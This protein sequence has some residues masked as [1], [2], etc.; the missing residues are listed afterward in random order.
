MSNFYIKKYFLKELALLN[1]EIY[2]YILIKHVNHAR[3][4]HNRTALEIICCTSYF[5]PNEGSIESLHVVF[6][7]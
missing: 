7:W 1:L 5:H 3:Y 2:I 4:Y 6:V